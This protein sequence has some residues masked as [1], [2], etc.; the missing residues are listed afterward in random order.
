MQILVNDEPLD[1]TLEHEQ[2]LGEVIDALADWLAEAQCTITAISVDNVVNPIHDR[3]GWE[4]VPKDA[5]E[6]LAIEAQSFDEAQSSTLAALDEFFALLDEALSGS[7]ADAILDLSKELPFVRSRLGALFPSMSSEQGSWALSDPHLCA[8]NPPPA[9]RAAEIQGEISRFRTLLQ[10]RAREYADPDRE[11][12]LTLGQLTAM[13]DTLVEVPVFLQTGRQGEAMATVVQLTELLARVVRM[14]PRVSS[15]VLDKEGLASFTRDVTPFLGEM[16][17]ALEVEDSVL[18]GDLLEY[19]IA[20]RVRELQKL[21]P[22][23]ES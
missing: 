14:L 8:G 3:S 21:V 23:G 1:V 19:E 12:F 22:S 7:H 11:T 15:D 4:S 9:N 18:I 20:P 13:A 5:V 17:H 2:T 6:R 10:I 16:E